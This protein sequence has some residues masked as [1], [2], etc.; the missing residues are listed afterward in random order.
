[1]WEFK[2]AFGY[3]RSVVCVFLRP[4]GQ[5]NA[6]HIRS[7]VSHML[8]MSGS[9]IGSRQRKVQG[10]KIRTDELMLL[11]NEFRQYQ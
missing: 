1:M 11:N 6:H 4:T 8:F 9:F 2:Y 10:Q 3:G 7:Q 5:R